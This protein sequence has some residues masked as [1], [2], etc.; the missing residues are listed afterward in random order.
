M[1]ASFSFAS[2]AHVTQQSNYLTQRAEILS[3]RSNLM[4]QRA[5]NTVNDLSVVSVVPQL[6]EGTELFYKVRQSPCIWRAF[7][8]HLDC[9][10]L[11]IDLGFFG[12]TGL[13]VMLFCGI[14]MVGRAPNF[15]FFNVIFSLCTSKDKKEILIKGSNQ[16]EQ[17]VRPKTSNLK[18]FV[19]T[20]P[21]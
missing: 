18:P 3:R 4:P 6:L 10:L 14:L 12:M 5:K 21:I 17:S 19:V 20:G 16:C 13:A 9:S 2:M 15:G 8:Q 11:Q 7:S 1:I